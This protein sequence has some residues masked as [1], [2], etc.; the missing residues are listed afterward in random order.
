MTYALP[1]LRGQAAGV[2]VAAPTATGCEGQ[3]VR[4]APFQQS[5]GAVIRLLPPGSEHER[6]LSGVG[7]YRLGGNRGEA[8][9]ISSGSGCVVVSIINGA[10]R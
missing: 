4:V 5:C 3:F 7:L 6:D 9:F 10:Q 2:L 1:E 8:M